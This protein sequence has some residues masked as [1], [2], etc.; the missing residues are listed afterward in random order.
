MSLRTY[1]FDVNGK[2]IRIKARKDDAKGMVRILKLVGGDIRRHCR[3]LYGVIGENEKGADYFSPFSAPVELA[4]EESFQAEAQEFFDSLPDL[5]TLDAWPDIKARALEIYEKHVPVS[6]KRQTP[7]ERAEQIRKSN[8]RAA[9]EERKS[10][11]K[12]EAMEKEQAKLLQQYDYL[13]PGSFSDYAVA[14]KN[15]RTELKRKYPGHKFQVRSNSFSLGDSI[16]VRWTD[17]PTEEEVSKI[18]GKYQQGNFDGMQDMYID[19]YWAPWANTFGGSKYVQT[20]RDLSEQVRKQIAADL[21]YSDYNPLDSDIPDQVHM[22]IRR[23]AADTSFYTPQQQEETA[24]D[25][26]TDTRVEIRANQQKQGIEIRFSQKPAPGILAIL[27]ENGFRWHKKRK[28][29]YAKQTTK[30]WAVAHD[31]AER[32]QVEIKDAA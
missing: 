16:D 17:G 20:H 14:A 5:I 30:T 8:E 2:E 27:R 19:D 29:W 28:F 18:V 31:I 11:A 12:K 26:G 21:G 32:Y 13:E 23:I 3:E 7:E 10:R 22:E 25:T 15:I 6:D 1:K 9:E 4:D 24:E